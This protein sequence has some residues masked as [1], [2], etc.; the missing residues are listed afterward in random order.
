MDL[1]AGAFSSSFVLI[2]I[3]I[4]P[5]ALISARLIHHPRRDTVANR[6]TS[7]FCIVANTPTQLEIYYLPL[8]RSSQAGLAQAFDSLTVHVVTV[9]VFKSFPSPLAE[10]NSKQWRRELFSM[11]PGTGSST[12][13]P[14]KQLGL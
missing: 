4:F 6:A 14:P 11:R 10:S 5:P 7:S 2:F 1:I 3:I 9:I 13:D 12:M 8:I